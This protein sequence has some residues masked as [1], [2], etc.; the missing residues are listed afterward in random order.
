MQAHWE[1][2]KND[3][4]RLHFF[5]AI[6][7]WVF[8]IGLG[9]VIRMCF[10]LSNSDL[11]RIDRFKEIIEINSVPIWHT[12]AHI[13]MQN[14]VYVQNNAVNSLNKYGRLLT[15]AIPEEIKLKMVTMKSN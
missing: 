9:Y 8:A 14:L 2:V 12:Q 5:L 11:I 1:L 3:D 6:F 4:K 15:G 13:A 10:G 7:R